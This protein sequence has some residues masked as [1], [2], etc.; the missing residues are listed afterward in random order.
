MALRNIVTEGDDI[1]RKRS[2]EVNEINDRII[3]ILDDML[4]TMRYYNG[5][6]IAAPQ[7]GVLKRIFIV[8]VE[9]QLFELIN[10]EIVEESGS[11]VDEEACLSVPGVIGIVDRPNYVKIKGLNRN[12]EEVVY[13]GKD[14]LAKAFCHEYD[15][16]NGTLFIDKATDIRN[17][18]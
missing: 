8:E 3:M 12:G 2:R 1:L 4:E 7:V 5:V 17:V 18:E 16:L 9:D 10:P 15:H 14:F 13:E 6:G 11:Y